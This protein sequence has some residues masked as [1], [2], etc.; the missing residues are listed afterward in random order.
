METLTSVVSAAFVAGERSRS[1]QR[2]RKDERRLRTCPC[3][4]VYI[5]DC[6]QLN[7]VCH[8]VAEYRRYR[9]DYPRL[10]GFLRASWRC[11]IIFAASII[12]PASALRRLENGKMTAID[13]F[14]AAICVASPRCDIRWRR[15]YF[16]LSSSDSALA[17]SSPR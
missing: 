11:L 14:N 10:G 13:E 3:D 9:E 1:M 4:D 6:F 17:F 7:R 15:N 12:S 2:C 5:L 16:C 8:P